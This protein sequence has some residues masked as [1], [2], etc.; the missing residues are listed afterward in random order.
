MFNINK[1]FIL[2]NNLSIKFQDTHTNE[3]NI[4]FCLQYDMF[5]TI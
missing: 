2:I 3:K 1:L 5:Y 4:C